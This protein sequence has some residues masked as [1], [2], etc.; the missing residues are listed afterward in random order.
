MLYSYVGTTYVDG[1]TYL[2]YAL[3][4]DNGTNA[5]GVNMHIWNAAYNGTTQTISLE[6]TSYDTYIIQ[7]KCSNYARVASLSNNICDNGVNIHQ[8]E[9]S[10]HFHDQWIFEPVEQYP[11]L[12]IE[13][14]KANWNRRIEA[15][16]DFSEWGGD[17][18]NFVSQCLLASG[19]YMNSS[20]WYVNKKN[21]YYWTVLNYFQYSHSWNCS[22][23]WMNANG[24]KNN[25]CNSSTL[26]CT[27]QFILDYP[28][29]IFALNI[30]EG[31]VIQYAESSGGAPGTSHHSM[32]IRGNTVDS[33]NGTNYATYDLTWH[34]TDCETASLIEVA[35]RHLDDVFLFYDFTN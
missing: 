14:A 17:C 6:K 12:G 19:N 15:F 2:N 24:F 27:G 35:S 22:S 32:F 20:S 31:D 21:T 34:S 16:P 4:I 1:L 29:T 9:Y 3:D 11:E 33:I 30:Q 18:T 26:Y 23:S 7:T 28:E 5:N 8:W 25:F 10:N 13:Y